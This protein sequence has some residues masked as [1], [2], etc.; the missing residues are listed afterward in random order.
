MIMETPYYRGNLEQLS[1]YGNVTRKAPAR[2]IAPYGFIEN[3]GLILKHY[4]MHEQSQMF[5]T[6]EN[7]SKVRSLLKRDVG[8]GDINPR[9]GMGFSVQSPSILNVCIFDQDYPDV[10]FPQI[11]SHLLND[12][13]DPQ[14]IKKYGAFCSGE[15]KVYGHELNAWLEYLGSGKTNGDKR[16]YLNDF[17]AE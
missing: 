11:Y 17:L 16:T 14:D 12:F 6:E 9:S 8:S 1:D 5:P 7:I 10:V 13:W 3:K 15:G 2:K 4:L